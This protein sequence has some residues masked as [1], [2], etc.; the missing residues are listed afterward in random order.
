ME[1]RLHHCLSKFDRSVFLILK[2]ISYFFLA[3]IWLGFL[4]KNY[5]SSLDHD[6]MASIWEKAISISAGNLNSGRSYL[7]TAVPV[8]SRDFSLVFVLLRISCYANWPD[9]L[10]EK[11]VLVIEKNFCKFE[12]KGWEFAKF[13]I[14]KQFIWTIFETEY[15]FNLLMDVSQI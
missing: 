12:A 5:W 8:F 9:L 2:S 15:F 14:T 6:L 10:W 4:S 7:I 13:E 3:F 11:I 1:Y